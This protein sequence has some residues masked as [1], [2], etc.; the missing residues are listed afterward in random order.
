MF[1]PRALSIEDQQA[2]ELVL[3][4]VSQSGNKELQSALANQRRVTP[5][6]DSMS[7]RIVRGSQ[8]A[9]SKS[10]FARPAG[11]LDKRPA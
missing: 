9:T 4:L 11:W 7:E 5:G 6:M 1:R 3:N 2:E 10:M 8:P